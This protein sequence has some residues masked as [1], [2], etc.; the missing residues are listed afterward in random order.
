MALVV[1]TEVTHKKIRDIVKGF[2]LVH[3]VAIFDVYTGEQVPTGKKSLAYRV[4]FQ[5]PDHTLTDEEVNQVQQ[6]ILSKLSG[7]LGATLRS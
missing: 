6:Q 5:S 1:D 7:E 3:Q 2:P 4:T